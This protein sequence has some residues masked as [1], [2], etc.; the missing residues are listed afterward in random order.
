MNAELL[1]EVAG[2]YE[3][4]NADATRGL[5]SRLEALGDQGIV[6]LNLFRACKASERAKVYTRRFKGS[7]YDKKE[8]SMENLCRVL[9]RDAVA[10][11]VPSWGWGRDDKAVGY[12]HVLYVDTPAGQVSFHTAHRGAGPDYK[13]PWDGVK[14]ASSGRIV[15][16]CA[17]LLADQVAA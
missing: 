4:S 16:W 10:A 15:Q 17:Q 7:A 13:K 11:G 6:A 8:W 5:Y 1:R 12:E 9:V 3:G 14:G 2:I